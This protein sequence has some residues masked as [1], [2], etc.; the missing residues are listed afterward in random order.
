MFVKW[1]IIDIEGNGEKPI[2]RKGGSL[3]LKMNQEE[4]M[5]IKARITDA[6]RGYGYRL[7]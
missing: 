3:T 7:I 4:A 2:D 5:V 1:E 6:I